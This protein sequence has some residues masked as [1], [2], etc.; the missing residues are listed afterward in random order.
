M[1][2]V[3]SRPGDRWAAG[4]RVWAAT[5]PCSGPGSRLTASQASGGPRRRPEGSWG[6]SGPFKASG[7]PEA[8]FDPAGCEMTAPALRCAACH[9]RLKR[10]SSSGLGPVCEKRL[11]PSVGTTTPATASS[12]PVPVHEGQT[13]LPIVVDPS[14]AEPTRKATA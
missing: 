6:L 11:N 3:E 8:Q 2:R 4:A 14:A 5:G 7:L 12:G 10:P 13:E 9:R 1:S